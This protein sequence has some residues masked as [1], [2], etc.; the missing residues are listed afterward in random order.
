MAGI[1]ERLMSYYREG[2]AVVL[3]RLLI[4]G[5]AGERYLRGKSSRSLAI[6]NDRR[7]KLDQIL[8][9]MPKRRRLSTL[10]RQIVTANAL[11]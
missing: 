9:L 7:E 3:M 11:P 1:T 4:S 8:L 10:A 2:I 6:Y 5:T